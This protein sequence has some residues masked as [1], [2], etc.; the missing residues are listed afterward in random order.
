MGSSVLA[1]PWAIEQAGFELGLAAMVMMAS[2]AYYTC[3]IVLESGR[4]GRRELAPA[5]AWACVACMHLWLVSMYLLPAY[6]MPACSQ[7]PGRGVCGC[8]P[9]LLGQ[10]GLRGGRHF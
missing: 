8:L 7:R 5:Q 10:P 3:S 1:M 6:S 9:P 4:G 2:L